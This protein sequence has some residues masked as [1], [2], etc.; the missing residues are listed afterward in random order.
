M[1]DLR[2]PIC[3]QSNIFLFLYPQCRLEETTAAL[4]LSVKIW[5]ESTLQQFYDSAKHNFTSMAS[6]FF[7]QKE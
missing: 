6:K 4:K 3:K 1:K 7:V 5:F 2:K